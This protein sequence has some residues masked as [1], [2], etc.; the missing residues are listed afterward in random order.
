MSAAVSEP[1]GQPSP[2]Y[3]DAHH[4][5]RAA[6]WTGPLPLPPG[7]KQPPPQGWTGWDSPDPSAADS[8]SWATEAPV[9]G[10]ADFRGTG[11]L[12]L[13]MPVCG[14]WQV[15]GIDVDHYD[16]KRGADTMREAVGRWGLLPPGPHSSARGD[17]SSAI[18]FFRVPKGTALQTLIKFPDAGPIDMKSGR[19]MGLG[20]VEIVQRHHRYAVAWPSVHPDLGSQYRWYGKP[21]ATPVGDGVWIPNVLD[22]PELPA[23]WVQ[24]LAGASEPG[25]SA[26]DPVTVA[27]F[28]KR[29]AG[30]ADQAKVRGVMTMWERNRAFEARHDAM[31]KVCCMAAREARMGHYPAALIRGQLREAF[32]AAMAKPGAGQRAPSPAEVRREFD[33]MWA[34][35]VSAALKETEHELVERRDRSATAAASARPSAEDFWMDEGEVPRPPG[36]APAGDELGGGDGGDGQAEPEQERSSWAPVDLGPIL[37]GEVVP[38]QPSIGLVRSDGVRLLYPG[39]EHA[40]IGEMESG[41]SWL[42]LQCCVAE[43]AAGH[44]VIYVHFE[45]DDPTD[46]VTRLMLLGMEAHVVLERFH[47][48][49]PTYGVT[50]DVMARLCEVRPSLVVLDGQNEAMT[51]HGQGINDPEGP[52]KYRRALVRP[53]TAQGAAVLSTDH[54]VKDSDRNAKGYANGNMMKGNGLTGALIVLENSEAFG[55]ARRG[56]SRVYVTKDRPA[57]VRQHGQPTEVA[58]KFFMGMLTVDATVKPDERVDLSFW[59]P[60][61]DASPSPF[62]L[63]TEW[64]SVLDDGAVLPQEIAALAGAGNAAARDIFRIVRWVG[65][66][67]GLTLAQVQRALS[68]GP[69]Q[70]SKSSTLRG[71]ALLQEDGVNALVIGSSP[72]RRS[73]HD[74]FQKASG[75][76]AGQELTPS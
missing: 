34:W 14:Q 29:Y 72:Q 22:L 64:H 9:T 52:S 23:A 19:P 35:G 15:I 11:Q 66:P 53:F 42:A 40:V 5:Y 13:R 26:A 25:V 6:G 32:M 4:L 38:A 12:A 62:D 74:R 47:F 37:R 45:E 57:Q 61:D 50:P 56:A 60:T 75:V 24:A 44:H 27:E 68:E 8:H 63:V 39:K 43:L 21:E 46:T 3:A 2:L 1:D 28:A 10:G 36:I 16:S 30:G 41:K 51:L 65:D 59:A 70:H 73:L 71:W 33:D 18:W 49:A 48:I 20:H 58:R 69:R 55:K 7:K 67:E 76:S 17:G 31:H 54:M